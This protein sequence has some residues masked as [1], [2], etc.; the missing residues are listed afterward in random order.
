MGNPRHNP[1]RSFVICR[2]VLSRNARRRAVIRLVAVL[3]LFALITASS[4]RAALVLP[5]DP[6]D[7]QSCLVAFDYLR[8]SPTARKVIERLQNS[9]TEYRIKVGYP[10]FSLDQ[11][12][13]GYSDRMIYWLPT[14]AM[15]WRTWSLGQVRRRS[16]ALI[17]LHELG[18]AYHDDLSPQ[19]LEARR[20]SNRRDPR[21]GNAEERRTIQEVENRAALELGEPERQW[22]DSNWAVHFRTFVSIGPASVTERREWPGFSDL[23]SMT[24]RGHSD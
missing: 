15:E 18:H 5:G 24:G 10:P 16:P 23:W 2:P 1:G 4:L 22:H 6:K 13:G 3:S 20:R 17:L 21:W 7:A 19:H 11:M 14:D 12:A 9:P 8:Q